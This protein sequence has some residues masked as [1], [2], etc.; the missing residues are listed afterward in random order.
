M[1]TGKLAKRQ[2]L[3]NKFDIVYVTQ[4]AVKG[5]ALADHLAENPVGGEYK[6]L[7]MYFPDEEVSFVEE[8]IAKAYDGWRMLFDGATN[9]KGLGIRAVLVSETDKNFSDPIP[10]RI[11]KQSAYCAHVEEETDGKPW[12]HDIKEYL[13]KGEYLE[14]VN[15]TQKCTVRRLSNHFFHSGGNLYRRTPDLGLLRCVDT[16]EASKLLEDIHAGTCGPHMNGFVLAKILRAGYFW[17]TMET[18]CIQ[19]VCKCYQFQVYAD[20]IKV[21]PNELNATS[22]PWPFT[23]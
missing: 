4:K 1:P 16:K 11:H 7:K 23:T 5:Q 14:H 19:Y 10:V 8:Y 13:A 21:P 22:S 20:M 12:F 2:I 3:L 17:M 15:H 9:F 6:P 18:N